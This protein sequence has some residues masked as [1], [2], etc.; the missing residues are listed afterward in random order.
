LLAV[1][2][3]G[4]VLTVALVAPGIIQVFG[5]LI[6]KYGRSNLYP[7][8][9]KTRFNSLRSQGLVTISERE[10]KTTIRLTKAGQRKVLSYRADELAI[11]PQRHWDGK[12]RLIFFDIP[13]KK[14]V[15]RN[16]FRD[17]LKELG[18]E[19]VQYSVW[20][21]R[22]PCRDE[23]EFLVNLYEID[24]YVELIEGKALV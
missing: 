12:W 17:R 10:G 23:I 15:A 24:R 3:S 18:F 5:P 21:H 4:G 14:A 6:K 11:K 16:A 8:R 9:V 19:R 2:I 7:S 13:E 20:R 1:A 22:Y